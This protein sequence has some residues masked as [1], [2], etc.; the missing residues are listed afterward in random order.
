[1]RHTLIICCCLLLAACSTLEPNIAAY[2]DN[3]SLAANEGYLVFGT[4]SSNPSIQIEFNSGLK[5]FLTPAF[6][7]GAQ[8]QVMVLPAGDYR[9]TALYAGAVQ[10]KAD[11][12]SSFHGWE[13]AIQPGKIN[14]FGE[15][16]L[17]GNNMRMY[18]NFKG[19]QQITAM[20]YPQLAEQYA[21]VESRRS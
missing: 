10:F 21:F 4:Y 14:Y 5:T 9:L 3:Q 15:L 1:M 7:A 17:D 19:I 12:A 16:Q 2:N 11:H 8:H 13:F 6:P 20:K 18:Y